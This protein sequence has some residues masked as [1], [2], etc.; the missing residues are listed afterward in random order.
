MRSVVALF[1]GGLFGAGLTVSGMTNTTKVQGWLDLSGEWDPTLAFV[2]GGAIVPMLV[3]WAVARRRTRA[4]LGSPLPG[5]A[6][7]V[8]DRRLMGGSLLFGTG[9][10]LVGLCPGPAM[11]VL[12]FGGWPAF[13]FFAAMVLG[14]MAKPRLFAERVRHA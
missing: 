9:W 7:P 1:C 4:V 6:D 8:I 3:A 2:L 11:A 13:L 5:P 10:A 12:G 14:M